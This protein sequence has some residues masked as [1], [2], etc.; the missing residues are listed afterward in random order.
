M[1]ESLA[2]TRVLDIH[3]S[4]PMRVS[5]KEPVE[6]EPMKKI[7]GIRRFSNKEMRLTKNLWEQCRSQVKI[8]DRS[9][10]NRTVMYP[11]L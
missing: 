11:E 7:D 5:M 4:K 3:Q 10:R 9:G 2:L 1:S 6:L 8:V